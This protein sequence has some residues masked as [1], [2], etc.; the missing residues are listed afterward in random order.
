[1]LQ[2]L[3]LSKISSLHEEFELELVISYCYY[4]KLQEHESWD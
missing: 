2:G 4:K 3:E 1:M